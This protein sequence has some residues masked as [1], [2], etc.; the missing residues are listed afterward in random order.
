MTIS[1]KKIDNQNTDEIKKIYKDSF[2]VDEM[3]PYDML[4]EIS[5]DRDHLFYAIYDDDA[6][7][8]MNYLILREDLL[9]VLYL[10]IGKDHQS[11][12]YG[13]IVIN[14]IIKR[15]PQKRIFL[16]IEEVDPKYAN[17]SQRVK[18]KAFY[19]SLGFVSQKYL[20]ISGK[21][22][23]LETMTINGSV[24]Y[25]EVNKLFDYFKTLD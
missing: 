8:G 16:N 10:A 22:V 19:Q 13:K 25:E 18:R 9:Y 11:K 23:S 24:S 14:E 12:G 1:F 4:I 6:L 21:G 2:P 15:Y 7:I 17:Y 5:N 3:F 20:Y